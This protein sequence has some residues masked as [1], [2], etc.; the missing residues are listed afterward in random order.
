MGRG[1][2]GKMMNN[3]KSLDD[4][5]D[6]DV[7]INDDNEVKDKNTNE[8]ITNNKSSSSSTTTTTVDNKKGKD[9]KKTT[10]TKTKQ[11]RITDAYFRV[12]VRDNGCGMAHDA[13]PE[14]LGR[15]LTGSKYGVRQTRGKFGLGAKMALIWSKKSTGIPI[16]VISSHMQQQQQQ[17]EEE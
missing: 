11:K 12:N 2:G 1:I 15:V 9:N 4:D 17:Q 6:E 13:I 5:N 14:L 3:K 16:T 8:K 10:K 7:N